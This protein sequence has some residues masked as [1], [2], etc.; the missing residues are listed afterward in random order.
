MKTLLVKRP[1]D[2]SP[3]EVRDAIFKFEKGM[4]EIP[5]AK[6]GDD[7]AI[8][9][10]TFVNKQ[11]VREMFV[12][13]GMVVVT[14]IHKEDHPYFVLKGDL[15]IITE[16]GIV[17]IKAPYFGITRAGTKRIAYIHEDTIWTTI[18][19]TDTTD[20][21]EIEAKVIAKK[22]DEVLPYTKVVELLTHHKLL[23]IR[24]EE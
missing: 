3:N 21:D 19:V 9:K 15:S 2:I 6:F 7:G 17:R 5:G 10:H 1:K 13:K 14:K 23:T 11:Y 4:S 18:H 24:R 20:L 8:L 12:T 16:K 22:Y